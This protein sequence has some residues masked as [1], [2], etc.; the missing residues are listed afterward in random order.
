MSSTPAQSSQLLQSPPSK[1]SLQITGVSSTPTQSSISTPPSKDS[2]Q[3]TGVSS[4]PTQSSIQ[5]L[6]SPP[7]KKQKFEHTPVQKSCHPNSDFS[8]QQP[9]TMN[10][11]SHQ[12]LQPSSQKSITQHTNSNQHTC[13]TR[14]LQSS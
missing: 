4:T 8:I 11:V 10:T 13:L 6:E 2:L 1:N 9:H 14:L 3:I 5:L 12:T 7:I